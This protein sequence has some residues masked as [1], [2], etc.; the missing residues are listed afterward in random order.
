MKIAADRWRYGRVG[1]RDDRRTSPARIAASP[2]VPRASNEPTSTSPHERPR[3]QRADPPAIA[4]RT[5]AGVSPSRRQPGVVAAKVTKVIQMTERTPRVTLT[6]QRPPSGC[7]GA[8]SLVGTCRFVPPCAEHLDVGL[9]RCTSRGDHV[10]GSGAAAGEVA[11]VAADPDVQPDAAIHSALGQGG[12]Q[13]GDAFAGA[14]V[15]QPCVCRVRD[16]QDGI[17]SACCEFGFQP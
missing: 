7:Q 1:R 8:A 12:H 3:P 13:P 6:R 5:H 10:L 9:G 2:H 15:V 14:V 16:H 4:P 17:S 11:R